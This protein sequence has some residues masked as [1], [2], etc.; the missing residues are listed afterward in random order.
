MV[1]QA[2]WHTR[3]IT[4]GG[5][6]VSPG[7]GAADFRTARLVK[8]YTTILAVGKKAPDSCLAGRQQ[9]TPEPADQSWQQLSMA[10]RNSFSDL[11]AASVTRCGSSDWVSVEDLR[12][13]SASCGWASS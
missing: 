7:I 12:I 1:D 2:A 9:A 3:H 6:H 8:T 5:G 11:R 10:W 4:V 13:S